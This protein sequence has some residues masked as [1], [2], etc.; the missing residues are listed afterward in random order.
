MLFVLLWLRELPFVLVELLEL[1]PVVVLLELCVPPWSVSRCIN[2]QPVIKAAAASNA[3]NCF[4]F[5]LV[6]C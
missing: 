1:V 5:V 6:L 4:I 2:E 3:I